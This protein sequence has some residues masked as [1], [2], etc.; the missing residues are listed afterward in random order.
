MSPTPLGSSQ[1]QAPRAART[2]CHSPAFILAGARGVQ[3][4]HRAVCPREG[5]SCPAVRSCDWQC[6]PGLLW[7]RGHPPV[8]TRGYQWGGPVVRQ[9]S[10]G[11]S[12]N[13]HSGLFCRAPPL[14]LTGWGESQ[15]SRFSLKYRSCIHGEAE[16]ARGKV[17]GCMATPPCWCI[18][19]RARWC[20][21]TWVCWHIGASVSPKG[22][23]Q[24]QPPWAWDQLQKGDDS[25]GIWGQGT[26]PNVVLGILHSS[27]VLSLS[28]LCSRP[29]A[30][31]TPHRCHPGPAPADTDQL[32]VPCDL[33]GAWGPLP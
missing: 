12:W 3:T 9:E 2:L 33:P 17:C 16:S 20:I 23:G 31:P 10:L 14:G 18:E 19:A 25:T 6:Q 26:E 7:Q 29:P 28:G 11:C 5:G 21:G 1:I 24:G 8:Q 32:G 27:L 4:R 13:I 15:K 30:P 22:R